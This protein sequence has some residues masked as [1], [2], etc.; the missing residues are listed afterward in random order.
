MADPG[1]VRVA[2]LRSPEAFRRHLEA[3]GSRSRSTRLW[4]RRPV[5][6][7]PT[8]RDGRPA[9]RQ[10]LLH[11]ADGGLGRHADGAPTELT[12]RRWR[13][14]GHSGAKLVWGGEAAAVRHDGRANPASS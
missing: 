10:P 14:F 6:L 5:A 7:R 8:A 9:G 2:T 12:R 3:C 4:R 1:W 11:P 13:H